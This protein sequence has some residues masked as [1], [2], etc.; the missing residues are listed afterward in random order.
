MNPKVLP[1]RPD[2]R[3]VRLLAHRPLVKR[4]AARMLS[5][6]PA[7]VEMDELVQ[8]G[9]IGLHEAL[10][11][12]EEGHGAT[13]DTYASRRIEG[14]MIDSLRAADALS[15]HVRQQQRE[16]RAA[17]QRLEHRLGRAPRAKEVAN[18]LGWPLEVFY[19]AMLD[20]GAAPMRLEDV[21]LEPPD[22]AGRAL[23][24]APQAIV[25]DQGDPQKLLQ[26][27][28]RHE[29]LARA[30]DQLDPQSLQVMEMIYAR[31]LDLAEIGAHLGLS[32][33]R[34]SQIHQGAVATLRRRMRD[35]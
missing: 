3:D 32:P 7:H 19:K 34:I 25:D 13:F 2:E 4:I 31:E 22:D 29:A 9:M 35:W 17:V 16:I 24:D 33:S 28:Q 27:R 18:A 8:A 20:I 11:R 30:F 12:F 15:R 23:A 10:Q 5:R 1:E 21:A 6:L 14:S 26:R